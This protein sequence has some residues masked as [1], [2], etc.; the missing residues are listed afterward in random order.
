MVMLHRLLCVRQARFYYAKP[1]LGP[2]GP[3]KVPGRKSKVG[4]FDFG[5]LTFDLKLVP[6]AGLA[7]A[8]TAPS[9]LCLYWLGYVGLEIGAPTRS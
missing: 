1:A 5:L 8:L 7:P 3:S 2:M 4:T 6:T 9:T